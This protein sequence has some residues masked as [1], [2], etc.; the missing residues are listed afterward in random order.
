MKEPKFGIIAVDYE[1]HVPRQGMIDGLQSIANQTYKN[2]E[3]IICHDG[4]KE[5][6]YSDEIDFDKMG[7]KPHIIN[8]PKHNGEWGHYSRDYAMKY[9]YKNI[10]DCNYYIQFN[11]DNKFELNA[12]EVISDKIKQTKSD[13]IIFTV[14]HYKA[15]GGRPFIGVPPVNCNIDVMQLVA[16]KKIW[17]KEGFWYRYEGVS[18]G[19]IY[20]KMCNENSWVNIEE[21]LGDNY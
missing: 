4:P 8:T 13:I 12:F 3:I 6:P 17:K 1:N 7:L 21:C 15:A 10:P 20:E 5:K 11:I 18:D 16:H 9:A 2:F 19:L 14:R